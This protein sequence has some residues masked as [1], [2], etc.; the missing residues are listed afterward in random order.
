M[1]RKEFSELLTKHRQEAGLS[2]NE[3]VRRTGRGFQQ[4]QRIEKASSNYSIDN[5]FLYLK[6]MQSCIIL[7]NNSGDDRYYLHNREEF[8]LAFVN[9]RKLMGVSQINV[10]G[11]LMVSR[12]VIAGIENNTLNT[13]IDKFIQCI[14]GLGYNIDIVSEN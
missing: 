2:I 12:N 1:D 6:V 11:H 14:I 9:I 3:I 10:A 7:Y 13:S 5:V 8:A 4:I